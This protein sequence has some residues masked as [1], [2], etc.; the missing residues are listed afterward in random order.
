MSPAGTSCAHQ[1]LLFEDTVDGGERGL[2]QAFIASRDRQ[3]AVGQV[4]ILLTF[5]HHHNLVD[6]LSQHPMQRIFG[7]RAQIGQAPSLASPLLPANDAPMLDRQQR[8]TAPH[9]NTLL[10]GGL[11]HGENV[12]FGLLVDP[13]AGYRS[14]EPP[15]VFFSQDRQFDRQV[16]QSSLLF[17]EFVF[18]G[19]VGLDADLALLAPRFGAQPL[20]SPFL[21]L[22]TDAGQIG[23][24]EAFPA[25]E[26]ANGLI[27]VLSF[28]VDLELL[29]GAQKPPLPFRALVRS[30][31]WIGMG[32]FSVSFWTARE[33][34]WFRSPYGLPP[35]LPLPPPCSVIQ[36]CF[37]VTNSETAGQNAGNDSA[38][39]TS[40]PT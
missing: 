35:P 40:P 1:V 26:F 5:S 8:T 20:E 24:V 27:A 31:R 16:R 39:Y 2:E 25:Q 17:L 4:N 32:H 10:M 6:L 14:H 18:D 21:D 11:N 9:R 7:T 19:V 3:N 13:L 38:S 33:R 12:H 29:L 36:T 15:F 34:Q 37:E 30:F 22:L 23:R 28:Q